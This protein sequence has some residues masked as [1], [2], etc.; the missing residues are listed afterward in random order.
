MLKSI[1]IFIIIC[2]C[3][4]CSTVIKYPVIPINDSETIEEKQR[5]Y[6]LYKLF[7]DPV[8]S[9]FQSAYSI[10]ALST[11][12]NKN[13]QFEFST[14]N[15]DMDQEAINNFNTGMV[16]KMASGIL[17][18]VLST[19][20]TYMVMSFAP[21]SWG[22]TEKSLAI[23]LFYIAGIPLTLF[24]VQM[25]ANFYYLPKAAELNNAGLKK[26]LG[27]KDSTS[28]VKLFPELNYIPISINSD[29]VGIEMRVLS[30]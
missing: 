4:G 24:L 23:S 11:N 26:R 16:Y 15:F 14:I 3:M 8:K 5:L 2:L 30:F 10:S 1:L 21:S 17:S 28:G 27:L 12:T 22:W 29:S 7:Y 25:P 19:S 20:G 13:T 18:A 9:E 6:D